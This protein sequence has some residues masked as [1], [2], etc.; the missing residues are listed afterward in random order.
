ME[1][2]ICQITGGIS[3]VLL[4]YD[5][6][7]DINQQRLFSNITT[8]TKFN[9]WLQMAYYIAITPQYSSVSNDEFLNP[10]KMKQC[11]FT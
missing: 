10:I 1:N 8:K 2:F 9:D 11:T 6:S 5:Y 4:G 3:S 7:N